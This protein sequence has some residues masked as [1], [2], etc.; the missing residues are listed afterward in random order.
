MGAPPFPPASAGALSF[1]GPGIPGQPSLAQPRAGASQ[2]WVAAAIVAFIFLVGI[3][4]AV[5]AHQPPPAQIPI[6]YQPTDSPDKMFSVDA[7]KGWDSTMEGTPDTAESQVV[8]TSGSACINVISSETLSFAIGPDSDTPELMGIQKP[9]AERLQD[10]TKSDVSGKHNNYAESDPHKLLSDMGD[11]RISEFTGDGGLF[12]GKVHGLRVSIVGLRR[13]MLIVCHCPEANYTAL[14][15]V[16]LHVINS[17]R[18]GPG[19]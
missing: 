15:P 13:D 3:T 11:G 14:K 4:F 10:A 1:P 2:G 8:F 19:Q 7:P 17:L 9:A 6:A 16:F 12:V 18:P 5:R